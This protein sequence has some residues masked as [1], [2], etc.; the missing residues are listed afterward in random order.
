[1]TYN[2]TIYSVDN[3]L[4]K[5]L[6]TNLFNEIISTYYENNDNGFEILFKQYTEDSVKIIYHKYLIK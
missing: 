2:M 1:M 5:N 4:R 6:S 3:T